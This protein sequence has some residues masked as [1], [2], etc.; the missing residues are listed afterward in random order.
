MK[1]KENVW[2]GEQCWSSMKY[3]D[4]YKL[5]EMRKPHGDG[6]CWVRDVSVID[7]RDGG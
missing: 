3:I 7:E 1:N 5:K 4:R 2:V 6:G